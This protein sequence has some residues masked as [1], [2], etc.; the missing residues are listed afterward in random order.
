M[1]YLMWWRGTYKYKYLPES[2][3]LPITY[4]ILNPPA[5]DEGSH[6]FWIKNTIRTKGKIISTKIYRGN[7]KVLKISIPSADP[8]PDPNYYQNLIFR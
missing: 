2:K 5:Y 8:Q 4:L 1:D 7:I 3:K 6:T